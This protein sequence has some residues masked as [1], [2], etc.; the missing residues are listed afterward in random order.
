MKLK[1]FLFSILICLFCFPTVRAQVKPFSIIQ[2]LET[3]V[4]GEGTIHIQVDSKITDLLGTPSYNAGIDESAYVKVSGF[5]IQ[6]FMSNNSKTAKGEAERR[7]GLMRGVFPELATY[8]VYEAPNWK[9]LTGDFMTKE[10]AGIFKQ[11]IQKTFP[12]FGK[13][14][15]PI[16]NKINVFI[17]K[18]N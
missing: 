12:E 18:N 1:L 15:Y 7:A 8:I 16:S 4:S 11:K 14:I 6:V 17:Q 3:P 2:D 10:E 13:E 5:R 9:L